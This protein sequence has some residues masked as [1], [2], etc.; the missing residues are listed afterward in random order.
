MSQL[1]AS[2]VMPLYNTGALLHDTVASVLAQT[3]RNFELIL[4][5]DGSTDDTVERAQSIRDTRVRLIRRAQNGGVA[6][7]TNDGYA[8]A[9]GKYVL[10]ADHDDLLLPGRLECEIGYLEA[11]P[12]LDGV[13]AGHVILSRSVTW[14]RIRAARASRFG[15]GVAE[16]VVTA[17]SLW[18][19]ILFNPTVCFRRSVLERMPL[20]WDEQFSVGGDDE[21]FGRALAAGC[22][23]RILPDVVLRYR[24]YASSLSHR[25]RVR[26]ETARRKVAL[27]GLARILPDATDEER[28]L[29][30]RLTLRDSSLAPADLPKLQALFERMRDAARQVDWLDE[31]GL[32]EIMA[33]H[34]SRACALAACHDVRAGLRAYYAF[35]M[36]RPYVGSPLTILYQWQKRQV[37]V[38]LHH[39]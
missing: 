16:N 18:G 4:V 25:S 11:H 22:R 3:F 39:R 6:A 5:D 2:L 17:A 26:A 37:P 21:F 20:W 36:L 8:A 14:D 27:A 19:G 33:R 7:A 32:L 15:K 23:F 34:W 12:E 38:L 31:Q 1:V 28:T 35:P 13:G 9:R 29:H 24:R 30:C 10:P